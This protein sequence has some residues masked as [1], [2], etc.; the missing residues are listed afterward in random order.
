[1]RCTTLFRDYREGR[2]KGRVQE[3]GAAVEQGGKGAE[4]H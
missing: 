1:M 4:S 3:D 2:G